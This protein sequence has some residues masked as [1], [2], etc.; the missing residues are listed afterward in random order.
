MAT[1]KATGLIMPDA[2]AGTPGHITPR[3]AIAGHPGY[4]EVGATTLSQPGLPEGDAA[5]FQPEDDEMLG[6]FET[7]AVAI[8]HFPRGAAGNRNAAHHF[9]LSTV[10]RSRYTQS[11]PRY[12]HVVMP[13]PLEDGATGL[14]DPLDDEVYSV[15]ASEGEK[16]G[17]PHG[18]QGQAAAEA[19]KSNLA[20]E[21]DQ[22]M[23]DSE[24]SATGATGV[25]SFAGRT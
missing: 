18:G 3:L 25:W 21:V 14:P 23:S 17:Y 16:D 20:H 22:V 9:E 24:V 4:L 12:Y 13:T 6:G 2:V 1:T 11:N 15:S 7:G 10:I 19:R 5:T 8:P